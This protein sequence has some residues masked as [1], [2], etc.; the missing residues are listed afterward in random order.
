MKDLHSHLPPQQAGHAGLAPERP[1]ASSRAAGA[2][3]NTA[4][5]DVVVIAVGGFDPGG[6]A[7]VVRDFLTARTWGAAARLVPTAWTE[8]SSAGVASVEPRAPDAL[9][10]ALGAALGGGEPPSDAPRRVVKIGMIPDP[11]TLAALVG[12]LASFGGPI[13]WDPVLAASSGGA[14]F[15][16]D[17]AA[18]ETLIPRV[19]LMTPNAVEAAALTGLAVTSE[20]AA[21]AT[22]E[23]LVA[24]GARAVLVKGGHLDGAAAVEVLITASAT[25]RFS[26][27]RLPGPS[28]RGTGCALA[29]AIAVGLGRGLALPEAIARAKAW[30][31]DAIGG[32]VTVGNERHLS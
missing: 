30:L 32:A 3:T 2:D 10:R 8:Q 6:G 15:T 31:H 17:L 5:A 27:E 23:A 20:A 28:V 7:G 25:C 19:T 12:A 18:L 16:G 4:A 13:V 14:L 11:R 26:A 21:V 22:G 9:E 24:R 29:T 1:P